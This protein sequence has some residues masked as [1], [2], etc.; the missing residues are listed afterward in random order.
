MNAKITHIRLDI[1]K[2]VMCKYV[3]LTFWHEFHWLFNQ[4]KGI[5]AKRL[6]PFVDFIVI[7]GA[8]NL[9]TCT[10]SEMPFGHMQ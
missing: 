6:V 4:Y 3:G 10:H 9:I 5:H 8:T 2:N 1:F 7:S